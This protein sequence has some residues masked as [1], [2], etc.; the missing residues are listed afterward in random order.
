MTPMA[1]RSKPPVSTPPPTARAE[2]DA[3]EDRTILNGAIRSSLPPPPESKRDLAPGS[4][5]VGD[6]GMDQESFKRS[7]ARNLTY[8]LGKDE[9]GL[10]SFDLFF[11][12]AR[13]ARDRMV[14]RWNQTKRRTLHE[15]QKQVYYL[16]F[17][18]LLGRLLE[19]AL[20]NLGVRDQAQAALAE[21][22]VNLGEICE[23]ETDAGLGNA[24]LGRLAA[25]FLDS[26]ATLGLPA[27]A[28]GIRYEYGAFRQ[29]IVRGRQEEFADAWLQNGTPWEIPRPECRYPVKFG[30]RVWS[31]T[32][33]SGR[34][35]FQWVDTDNTETVEAMAYDVLVPGYRNG[36]VNTLRLWAAKATPEFNFRYAN[37]GDYIRAVED[38]NASENVARMLYPNDMVVQGRE[39]R[40]KQEYFF[41]SATLQ[42][43]IARHLRH[44]GDIRTLAEHA[45]FHLNDTQPA[46]AIA[47]LMHLLVDVHDLEWE[48]AWTITGQCMA[49]TNHTVL[50]EALE[51][52]PA[53]LLERVLP[54]QLQIIYEVNARFLTE[55]RTR[56]PGDEGRVQRVSLFDEVS[57]R[58][59]RMAH[60]ALVG[61]YSVNGVS[62][63]H[64]RLL[65]QQVFRDFADLFPQK[66]RAITNGITPRRWL[67]GCNPELSR[68]ITERIGDGWVSRLE[69][70]TQLVPAADE[71]DFRSAWSAVKRHNKERLSNELRRK[72]E[73]AV[74]PGTVF[75]VHVKRIHE[76]KRQLLNILHVVSLYLEYRE[77]PPSG[78]P[79]RSFIFAGKAAPGYAL[80]K[81]II[82]L[83]T[84]VAQVIAADPIVSQ[85]LKVFFLPDYRVSWAE[86]IV[87]AADVSEQISL[88]GM[89][90]SGTGNMKFVLNG[91][92]TVGTLDGANVEIL[93]AVG[94]D[95][96]F[97]FGLSA[98]EVDG[99]RTRGYMPREVY[100]QHPRV[101]GVIDAICRGTFS[102]GDPE[103]F[104]QVMDAL[105]YVDRYL[106]LADFESYRECHQAVAKAYQDSDG[107]ARRSILNTA[108]SGRFSSDVTVRSYARDIWGLG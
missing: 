67:L 74:D 7:V 16:S 53:W 54:R 5:E 63:L 1:R 75:D 87:P 45:V 37:E 4:L 28:Y 51:T 14:E 30:G 100:D 76:Y 103:R 41:V 39:L 72:F 3:R 57:E 78:V 96:I 68:L 29:A 90:A 89:E 64:G 13:A 79:P 56:H 33:A 35:R 91:A 17:E 88:A 34:T 55:V 94:E 38:K 73:I 61:C 101:R 66:F 104:R 18:F 107:W 60:L 70:L 81:R 99:L 98:G 15:S 50:P 24:G 92:V 95:N 19:D 26:M 49:Y 65:R 21:F 43:A 23:S 97:V 83:V 22:G 77:Q 62:Q 59:I 58:R 47:E 10:S 48:D 40:L 27:M 71:A 31:N 52:W 105:L 44:H 36:T 102:P 93:E 6:L 46:L 8:T 42:D 69:E 12:T 80:A 84:G 20:I 9:R 82:E 32:D 85:H 86:L 2:A 108:R 106:V 11:A 25:C